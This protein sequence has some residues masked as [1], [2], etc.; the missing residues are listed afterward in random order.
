MKKFHYSLALTTLCTALYSSTAYSAAAAAEEPSCWGR[1]KSFFTSC[2]TKQNIEGALETVAGTVIPV[3]ETL[4]NISGLPS[5]T[6]EIIIA[7]LEKVKKLAQMAGS[8]L[9]LQSDGSFKVTLK[10]GVSYVITAAWQTAISQ[11][12][13]LFTEESK[14]FLS[15]LNAWLTENKS[16]IMLGIVPLVILQDDPT[17]PD[18]MSYN[19]D[20]GD[21]ILTNG[22][23]TIGKKVNILGAVSDDSTKQK[24]QTACQEYYVAIQERTA[25]EAANGGQRSSQNFLPD[26]SFIRQQYT[27]LVANPTSVLINIV[28][29]TTSIG[30]VVDNVISNQPQ[31]SS[32][33]VPVASSSSSGGVAP[34]LVTDAA[35]DTPL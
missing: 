12:L 16:S 22:G 2:C 3:V 28:K 5:P 20:T 13:G 1:S 33:S 27:T 10:D 31:G 15:L 4:V 25:A 8:V 23:S 14:M 26:D 18:L 7:D 29:G 34:V 24:I 30:A 32:S 19:A 11:N 17:T 35:K 9:E 21:L 6:K